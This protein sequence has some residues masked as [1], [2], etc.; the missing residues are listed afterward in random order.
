[1]SRTDHSSI[2]IADKELARAATLS[3]ILYPVAWLIVSL[4]TEVADELPL[5]SLS[6]ILLLGLAFLAN[7]L[8]YRLQIWGDER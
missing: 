5:V 1:M 8:L 3:S 7:Y 6:G 4:T 2:N